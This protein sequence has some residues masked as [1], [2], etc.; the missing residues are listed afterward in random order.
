ME[1]PLEEDDDGLGQYDTAEQ[2][3]EAATVIDK[4]EMIEAVN[5]NQNLEN[6]ELDGVF[7]PIAS[8]D[9]VSA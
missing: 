7:N 6:M 4:D 3:V 2:G 8:R 5:C 1:I 9:I